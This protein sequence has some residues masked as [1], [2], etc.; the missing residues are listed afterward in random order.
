MVPQPNSANQPSRSTPLSIQPGVSHPS[1]GAIPIEYRS[2]GTFELGGGL[3]VG[4]IGF[5]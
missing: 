2:N 3:C 5:G 1:P 4:D